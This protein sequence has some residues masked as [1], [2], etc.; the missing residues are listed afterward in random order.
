MKCNI[1]GQI[2]KYFHY[3]ITS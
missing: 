1:F 2:P 3:Q